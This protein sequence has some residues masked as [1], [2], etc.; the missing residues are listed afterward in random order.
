MPPPPPPSGGAGLLCGHGPMRTAHGRRLS[1]LQGNST[2]CVPVSKERVH[3]LR[4]R[5]VSQEKELCSVEA[6]AEKRQ[7]AGW[8]SN[9]SDRRPVHAGKG[10][11]YGALSG[12]LPA[13][14]ETLDP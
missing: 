5:R 10:Q 7:Q 1:L 14:L 11:R 13:E 6:G 3:Q 4:G 2:G 12:L 9:S 8:N